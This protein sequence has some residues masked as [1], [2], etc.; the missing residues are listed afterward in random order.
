MTVRGGTG[1]SALEFLPARLSI[2]SMRQAVQGC[3]GCPLYAN[4]TQAVFGEG[5]RVARVILV[6]EQPGNDEDLQGRP[7]VGPAGRLLD[8]ALKEVG[9]DRDET[10]VTNVVKHFKWV[11]KGKRRMHQKPDGRDRSP[12]VD[13][14]SHHV[15]GAPSRAATLHAGAPGRRRPA[16]WQATSNRVTHGAAGC[17]GRTRDESISAAAA[18][19]SA[20]RGSPARSRS[21]RLRSRACPRD[22]A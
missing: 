16:K 12:V 5:A 4:A 19:P 17:R 13:S 11:A 9:I 10:Y 6:G 22:N 18:W 21:C 15:G 8:Q 3:R 2:T 20:H 14:A 1:I 7:F